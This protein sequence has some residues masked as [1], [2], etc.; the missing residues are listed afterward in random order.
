LVV[1]EPTVDGGLPSVPARRRRGEVAL[2]QPAP[3]PERHRLVDPQ[4]DPQSVTHVVRGERARIARHVHDGLLQHIFAVRMVNARLREMGLGTDAADLVDRVHAL[5]EQMNAEAR[6][7][8]M[9]LHSGYLPEGPADLRSAAE[10]QAD[11]LRR[12][13][14]VVASVGIRDEPL[15]TPSGLSELSGV[16]QEACNNLGRHA[17]PRSARIR[18][19]QIGRRYVITISDDGV[20]FDR[21]EVTFGFGLGGMRDRCRSI[22]AR[23]AVRSRPGRGTV[24][25][26][27][28]PLAGRP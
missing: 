24:V 3:T 18:G 15:L 25:R 4:I 8:I 2:T 10:Q 13:F 19:Y 16:I 27:S 11:R 7:A 9:S 23:L 22:S 6:T 20:G 17:R 26:V 21:R 1:H 12:L 28:I 14:R 5:L